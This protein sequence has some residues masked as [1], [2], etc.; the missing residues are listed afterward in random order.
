MQIHTKKKKIHIIV[1]PKKIHFSLH[2]EFKINL[3]KKF[4]DL[5]LN[6]QVHKNVKE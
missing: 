3:V 2:P 4:N 6:Q 1:K 5:V